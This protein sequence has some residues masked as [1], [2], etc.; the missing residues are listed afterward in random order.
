ML[1]KAKQ[2]IIKSLHTKK[3]REKHG[4]CLVEGDKFVDSIPP[5]LIDVTFSVSNVEHE[6]DFHALLTTQTPQQKAAIAKIPTWDMND[7][8][9]HKTVVLLAHIQ[10]PGNVGT[11]LRLCLGFDAHAV[12]FQCADPFSPKA[13]RSSAGAA[14]HVPQIAATEEEIRELL[15]Q[16]SV[17]KLEKRDSAETLDVTHQEK[18]LLVPGNEGSGVPD[19][20]SGT[21]QYINHDAALESLNVGHALAIALHQRY[22]R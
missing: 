3:G 4:L 5:E 14:F 16:F 19:W 20:I 11:M 2:K 12:L 8:T 1:S 22:T 17:V 15:P 6:S 7:V 10:D 13:L 18:L 9:N 21:S